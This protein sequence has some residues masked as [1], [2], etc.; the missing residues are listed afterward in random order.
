[1]IFVGVIVSWPVEESGE[2]RPGVVCPGNELMRWEMEVMRGT[3][4]KKMSTPARR[5]VTRVAIRQVMVVRRPEPV[6]VG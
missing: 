5:R 6:W 1:M 3:A 4:A 2:G